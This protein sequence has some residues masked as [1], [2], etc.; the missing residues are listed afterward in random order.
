MIGDEAQRRPGR[1]GMSGRMLRWL[2]FLVTILE[3]AVFIA[4]GRWIGFGWAVLFLLASGVI[5]MVALRVVGLSTWRRL[6]QQALTRSPNAA[7]ARDAL[8]GVG[9]RILGAF[10]LIVPG[11]VTSVVGLGLLIPPVG[12]AVSRRLP[13]PIIA[14]S[15][16]RARAD[17]PSGSRDSQAA[18]DVVEGEVVEVDIDDVDPPDRSAPDYRDV[19][20]VDEGRDE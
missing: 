17:R 20:P 13:R 3:I 4:V 5:G 7:Q 1:R 14:G 11:F 8:A 2:P 9:V 6:R 18:P 16:W 15:L 10:L 19:I 12:R